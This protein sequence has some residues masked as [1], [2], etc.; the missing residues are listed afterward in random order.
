MMAQRLLLGSLMAIIATGCGVEGTPVRVGAPAPDARV[1]DLATGDTISL[2]QRYAGQVTLVNIWATWCGPCRE[3]IPALDSLYRSLGPEGFRIA[4]V[5]IDD[6]PAE[7]IRKWITPFDVGFDVLQDRS[8]NIQKIFRTTGVPESFLI[9]KRGR[10]MRIVYSA[11]PWA[12]STNKRI[13][14]RLL[15]APAEGS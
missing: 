2:L 3:E 6:A 11:H 9:D 4:A 12:S 1:V 8:G 13:I 15:S 14:E 5:S 7:T 10:I